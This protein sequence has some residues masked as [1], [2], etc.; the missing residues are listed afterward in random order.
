MRCVI[1]CY[2]LTLFHIIMSAL[3]NGNASARQKDELVLLPDQELVYKRFI[4]PLLKSFLWTAVKVSVLSLLSLNVS[5]MI[6][7]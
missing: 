6:N 1:I 4:T 3:I 7:K 5:L 2:F